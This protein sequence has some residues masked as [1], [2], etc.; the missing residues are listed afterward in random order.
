MRHGDAT[1]ERSPGAAAVACS[2]YQGLASTGDRPSA[3]C[4]RGRS[5]SLWGVWINQLRSVAVGAG[6]KGGR[7]PQHGRIVQGAGALE[8]KGLA[9]ALAGPGSPCPARKR[10]RNL[11]PNK[12]ATRGPAQ[13]GAAEFVRRVWNSRQR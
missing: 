13:R 10:I 5:E 3:R 12:F 2:N 9:T 1:E 4:D 7:A 6:V 8:L 11:S